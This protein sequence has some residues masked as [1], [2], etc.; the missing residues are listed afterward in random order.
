MIKSYD[1]SECG[2]IF[3]VI[4]KNMF[5]GEIY[6]G[7]KVCDKCKKTKYDY[8]TNQLELTL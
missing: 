5:D 6:H 1:C 8:K 3:K 7:L 4:A 2:P